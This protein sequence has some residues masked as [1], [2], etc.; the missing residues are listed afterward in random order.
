[1]ANSEKSDKIERQRRIYI[2]SDASGQTCERV[3]DAALRQFKTTRVVKKIVPWVRTSEEIQKWF[4]EAASVNGVIIYTFVAPEHRQ[5]ITELGRLAG[6]PV[7]D[8]L[9]PLL[10]RFSDLLEISPM[11]QP[12][13]DKQLDD[14]YF[15]RIESIDFTIKH[16]DG[17]RLSS[18]NEAEIILLGVSRTTKTP[19]S[20]YLSYRGWKVSN[21]PIIDGLPKELQDVDRRKVAALTVKPSRLV[22]IRL[23]RQKYLKNVNLGEYTDPEQIEEEVSH[24]HRLY[25]EYGCPIIDVTFKSIEETST[26]V[27]RIIYAQTG[28]KKGKIH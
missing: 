23:E 27:M 6:V 22:L 26:E 14:D 28:L 17:Q 9:G 20:I 3:V 19:V 4:D 15:K 5:Q 7:I 13:L 25:R 8:L 11:A 12:G 16:D 1:M 18:L 21:I 10:T 2:I 24:S